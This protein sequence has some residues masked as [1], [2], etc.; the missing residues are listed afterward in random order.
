MSKLFEDLDEGET[1]ESGTHTVTKSEIV[2]FAEQFDPQPFHVDEAAA[3]DSMFGGLVASGLHTLSLATRLTVDDCLSEIANMGGS[4]MDELRWYTPVRPGDTLTVRAE[5]L[6][7]T[8]SDSHP[9]RGYVDF[10]RRVY[11]DDGDE[12][13]SVI[14][15]NIVRRRAADEDS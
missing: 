14:S 4:G 12:V 6:E 2:S 9:D 10:K 1:F 5:I 13:M 15:H 8:P 3:E 7:K 11:N